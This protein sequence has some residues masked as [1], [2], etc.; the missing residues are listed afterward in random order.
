MPLGLAQSD[1]GGGGRRS[2]LSSR[3]GKICGSCRLRTARAR[4]KKSDAATVGGGAFLQLH[5]AGPALL[6]DTV[7]RGR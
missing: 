7:R 3:A 5:I 6:A 4:T 1:G 2:E